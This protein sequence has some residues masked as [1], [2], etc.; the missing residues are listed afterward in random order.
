MMTQ[1]E[2]EKYQNLM[3]NVKERGKIMCLMGNGRFQFNGQWEGKGQRSHVWWAMEGSTSI[4]LL[5][6]ITISYYRIF[7]FPCS[8]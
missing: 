3:G 1:R 6:L 8:F 2:G 7:N 5:H 4:N